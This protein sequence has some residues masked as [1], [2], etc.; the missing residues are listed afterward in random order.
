MVLDVENATV[1]K[2]KC[3]SPPSGTQTPLSLIEKIRQSIALEKKFFSL[4]FFPPR[5][6]AGASNLIAKLDR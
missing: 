4:E 3:P 1:V 2:R 6:P 5:T